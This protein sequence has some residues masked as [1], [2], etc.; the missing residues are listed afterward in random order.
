M[1]HY[2]KNENFLAGIQDSRHQAILVAAD[3]EYN[4]ASNEAGMMKISPNV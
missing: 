4:A 2:Q 3:I 1:R